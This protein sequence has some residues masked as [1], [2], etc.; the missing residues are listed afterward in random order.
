MSLKG[1]KLYVPAPN[2][3][4]I[5][6]IRSDRRRRVRVR[7]HAYTHGNPRFGIHVDAHLYIHRYHYVGS[8][9]S[10]ISTYVLIQVYRST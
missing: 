6:N 7:P 9:G 2:F 1:R 8:Q 4:L 3:M 10:S 5:A